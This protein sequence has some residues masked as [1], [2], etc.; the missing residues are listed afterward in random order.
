MDW[1][2]SGDGLPAVSAL[3]REIHGYLARH[4]EPSCDIG[5]AELIVQELLVNGVEHADGPV[6]VHVSWQQ[7]RPVLV[8]RDLG[9]GFA[10]PAGEAA[11]PVPAKDVPE[12]LAEGGRGLFLVSHLAPLLEVA[13]RR[14]GGSEVKAE[15]PVRRA[16]SR[17]IDPPP[18][19]TAALPAL[20][21]AGPNGGFSK[22]EFLRALVV[23]LSQAV[24]HTVG[25]DVAED[26]VAQVGIA[27][28][29]Q[30][31]AEYRAA[32]QVVDRLSTQ[33]LAEC[34]VRLKHAIDGGFYVIE[35]TDD[36]IVL[37]NT[38]CPFG[39]AVR[40]SPALC[41]MTS[42]VFGGIASRN[43]D[44]GAA[45]VLEERIAVGDPGCRVVVYLAAPPE[46][47][48]GFAHRYRRGAEA[49]RD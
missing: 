8:V 32:K 21:E 44:H 47:A 10:L 45:V 48:R 16:A 39:E 33:Q 7:E 18:S 31:E 41:R 36:T 14:G 23:Q 20:D 24:E 5:D 22:E 13:A 40:T 42:S 3:R 26:V 19:T 12:L 27:V 29:G 35:L 1:Y 15:L 6:W 30:M 2:L 28:G 38:R 25:P 9:P 46:E 11:P 17:S 37:G 4:A 43:S 34:L 49:V